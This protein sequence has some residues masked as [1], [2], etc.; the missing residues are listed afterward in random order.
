MQSATAT[1]TIETVIEDEVWGLFVSTVHVA[2][3]NFEAA[4]APPPRNPARHSSR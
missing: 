4:P 3:V 1:E 2:Q